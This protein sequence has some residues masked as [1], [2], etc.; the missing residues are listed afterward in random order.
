MEKK[1]SLKIPEKLIKHLIWLW[2]GAINIGL[3]FGL[4]IHGRF[5]QGKIILFFLFIV[6]VFFAINGT[7]G[8]I[9]FFRDELHAAEDQLI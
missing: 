9:T 2:L 4:I 5:N 7:I 1:E 6:A 8:V 3:D